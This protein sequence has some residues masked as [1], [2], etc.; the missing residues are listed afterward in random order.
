MK[1]V[2]LTVL[3]II[4]TFSFSEAQE[5]LD[6]GWY[7]LSQPDSHF[8]L[9]AIL[10]QGDLAI[11][12]EDDELVFT[13]HGL[14]EITLEDGWTKYNY[15]GIDNNPNHF[16]F[17]KNPPDGDPVYEFEAEY[18]VMKESSFAPGK[19][20]LAGEMSGYCCSE[21]KSYDSIEDI[22]NIK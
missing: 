3:V 14:Q 4:Y 9:N 15:E 8:S 7:N 21:L 16:M 11:L 18:N 2:I 10:I 1:K 22:K 19:M 20:I 5:I 13:F 12:Y 17:R 6:D